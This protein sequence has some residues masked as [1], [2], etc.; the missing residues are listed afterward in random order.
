MLFTLLPRQCSGLLD[1]AY[2]Y[3]LSY[4]YIN[5]GVALAIMKRIPAEQSKGRVIL[6][7]AGLDGLA[8]A[9]KLMLFE[10]EVIVL[11]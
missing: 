2:N 4:A 8:A 6:I 10:F 5:F 3:L 1:F 7:G 9:R 11:E